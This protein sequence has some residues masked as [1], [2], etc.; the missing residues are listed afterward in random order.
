MAPRTVNQ[1]RVR[2]VW[3]FILGVGG[4]NW[5]PDVREKVFGRLGKESRKRERGINQFSLARRQREIFN[6]MASQIAL[7]LVWCALA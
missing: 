6:Y 1:A 5:G 3:V 2:I 4:L 7:D